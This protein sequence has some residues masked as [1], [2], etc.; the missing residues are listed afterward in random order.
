MMGEVIITDRRILI[1]EMVITYLEMALKNGCRE[2]EKEK[3]KRQQKWRHS[4]G[5]TSSGGVNNV[6]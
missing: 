1:K 5:G 3:Q 6:D 4:Y 2:K